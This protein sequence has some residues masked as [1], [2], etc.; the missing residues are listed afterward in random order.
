MAAGLPSAALT[1]AVVYHREAYFL[2]A[3]LLAETEAGTFVLDNLD[4]AL[5]CWDTPPWRWDLRERPDGQWTRFA[6]P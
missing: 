3:V 4:D 2:H 5:L 6:R 1:M